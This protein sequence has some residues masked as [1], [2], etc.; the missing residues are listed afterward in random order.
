MEN[1]DGS[2]ADSVESAANDLADYNPRVHQNAEN[3]YAHSNRK[4]LLRLIDIV[5]NHYPER[6]S[7]ALVVVGHDRRA[8]VR[9]VVRGT[10]AMSVAIKSPR[11]KDKIRFLRKFRELHEFV[12]QNVLVKLAGGN[13]PIKA[14]AFE[15]A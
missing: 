3:W 5:M 14:H 9:T 7:K 11:T 8:L 1:D 12:D 13:A 15:C 4:V 10:L 6:L 2:T